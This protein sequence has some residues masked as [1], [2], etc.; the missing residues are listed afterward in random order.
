MRCWVCGGRDSVLWK[1]R[2]IDRPLTADDLRITDAAYGVTLALWRCRSCGF[3]FADGDE[4]QQL[5][6]LY[7]R[8]ADPDY[9]GDRE[10]RALQMRWLIEKILESHRQ[11]R[12]LLDVGAGAGLLVAEARN[13][14]FDAL[15]VEPSHFL[16]EH[17]QR[18]HDVQLLQGVLPHP[19]LAGRRFDVVSLI[20]VVEHVTDPV[21]LLR[22]CAAMLNPG[23][24]VLVV[25]PDIGSLTARVMDGRWWHYR[26]AHIGYFS[27]ASIVSAAQQAGLQITSQFR[28]RWYFRVHYLAERLARY[29]PVERVNRLAQRRQLFRAL[30]ER[31]I[32][33]APRDSLGVLLTR[34]ESVR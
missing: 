33:L 12:T 7:E 28:P 8:L 9:L 27:S 5:T 26:V 1:P 23:G 6:V 4:L 20:D 21:G 30:Y 24:V 29:L 31:V 19:E 13:R 16:V 32:P 17:G 14:G 22:Q 3:V 11:A 18:A 15:G 10:P 25:T 2:S 34:V